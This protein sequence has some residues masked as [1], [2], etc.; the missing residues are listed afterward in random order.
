MK[1]YLL[2]FGF[3]L[4][5]KVNDIVILLGFLNGCIEFTPLEEW[6]GIVKM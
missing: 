2:L 4:F 5:A 6:I 1:K 3:L